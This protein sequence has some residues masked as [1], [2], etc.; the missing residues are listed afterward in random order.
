MLSAGAIGIKTNGALENTTGQIAGIG[1]ISIDTTKGAITNTRAGNISSASNVFVNSGRV[2]NTNGKIAA[3]GMVAINTNN[4]EL[5]NSGKGNTVGIEAGIVALET[6]TLNNRNG[7]IQGG[8][9]GAQS[10]NVNNNGGMMGALY[11]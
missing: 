8:Y 9:I 7:Q 3:T 5:T 4:T 2:D 1:D 6:G 10:T 11:T